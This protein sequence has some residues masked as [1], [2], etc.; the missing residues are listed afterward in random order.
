[1]MI[2]LFDRVENIVGKGKNAGS[3]FFPLCFLYLEETNFNFLFK[4][5]LSSANPFE[6]DKLLILW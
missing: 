5:T 3:P 4:Y 2:S 1:M 6:L